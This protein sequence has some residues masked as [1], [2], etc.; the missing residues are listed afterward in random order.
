DFVDRIRDRLQ[1]PLIIKGI[2]T[3]QDARL[4][5]Q[6]GADV[7]YV[8]NH[9]GRQLDHCLGS[10]EALPE[11]V[12][13]VD[14]RAEVV[15]DGGFVRGTDVLKAIALGAR[16][17]GLGKLQV[18]ALTAGGEKGLVRMLEILE[19][20]ISISMG[21]L[22][23]SKLDELTSDFVTQVAPVKYPGPLSPFPSIEGITR[24]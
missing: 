18:W 16:A 21:L 19:Q 24:D 7:V 2:A 3:A 20:E 1:V 17:V 10:I 15:V 22:G 12:K 6:H 14:G 8:S 23:I 9:G 4:A 13:A 11:V 5:I